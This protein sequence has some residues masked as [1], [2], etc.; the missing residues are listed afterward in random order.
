MSLPISPLVLN[1][2]LTSHAQA[3]ASYPP[4]LERKETSELIDH[5]LKRAGV[6][7]AATGI[8]AAAPVPD[9]PTTKVS[10]SQLSPTGEA[11]TTPELEARDKGKAYCDG[12]ILLYQPNCPHPSD[13]PTSVRPC[14]PTMLV[15]TCSR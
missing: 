11:T 3:A 12:S 9:A 7:E 14:L 15:N 13:K 10:V 4:I 8:T 1:H 5:V 2:V 6:V